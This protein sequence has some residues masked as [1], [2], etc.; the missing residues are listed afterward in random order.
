MR[1]LLSVYPDTARDRDEW[2]VARRGLRNTVDPL[3]PY[4]FFVEDERSAA[5]DI[6]PTAT[7][8]LTNRECRWRCVMCDLWRNTL[9]QS[10]PEG[11]IPGQIDYAL[12]RLPAARQ[13][14]LYNSGSFFD[15]RAI[16]PKDYPSIAARVTAFE[17]VIVECHPDLVGDACLGF[18]NLL[19]GKLEIAMGLETVHTETL[20]RLN[21]RMTKRKFASA[22]RWLRQNGIDLRVFILVRPPF[23]RVEDA[24]RWTIRSLE[25]AFT[26]G[27]AAATLIPTRGGNGAMEELAARGEFSPPTLRMLEDAAEQGISLH[28][29]R[30]FADLWNLEN[31]TGCPDCRDQRIA[32]LRAM[33]LEQKIPERVKCEVCGDS[34]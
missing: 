1:P 4:G 26:C 24:M 2:V 34:E 23:M 32:R 14:K 33:N 31:W 11:A 28:S 21:K 15:V 20:E 5:G 7:I 6:L 12:Q 22:A 9:T 3:R 19:S 29:G 8:F 27:A 10:V 17:R 16:P 18:R 13:I 30:V 25:F